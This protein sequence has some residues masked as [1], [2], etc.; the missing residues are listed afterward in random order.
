MK[1]CK[2]NS[3]KIWTVWK[4]GKS[5]GEMIWKIQK[6][7]VKRYGNYIRLTILPYHFKF[8]PYVSQFSSV[9]SKS[10]HTS[11]YISSIFSKSFHISSIFS[12][13]FHNFLVKWY[14]KYWRKVSWNMKWYGKYGRKA[15]WIVKR[16]ENMEERK[17]E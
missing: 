5:N 17:V 12:I 4:K 6:K 2:S 3:E 9:F 16:Y 15:S 14:W 10:F 1:K 11:T 13:S 7:I 8:L